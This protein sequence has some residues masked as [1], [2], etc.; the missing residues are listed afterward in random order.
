MQID[1]FFIYKLFSTSLFK[2]LFITFL[3]SYLYYSVI[4]NFK[5]PIY[6]LNSITYKQ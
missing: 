6:L 4:L 1:V 2:N 5:G 3:I